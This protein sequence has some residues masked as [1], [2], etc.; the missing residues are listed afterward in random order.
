MTR[1]R[2]L[3]AEDHETVRQALKLLIDGDRGM[4]VVGEARDGREAIARARGL[5][6]DVVVLDI[7]MPGMNGL[8]ATKA[9]HASTPAPAIVALTRYRD[10]AYV[11]ALLAAGAAGYVLKQ[12]PSAELLRAI[13][14]AAEGQTYLDAA[15][16]PS[17]S[18]PARDGR[19]AQ[20]PAI[21]DREGEV[22]RMT[23]LGHSNKEI[24]AALD[25]SV[26]TVEVHKA[27][28]MRKLGLR[29][30]IDVVRFAILQGW[31]QEP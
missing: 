29:G 26:K 22:L 20:R 8:E 21:T 23:A 10:E 6:P 16:A 2:V 4:T 25:L 17:A 28:A 7:S 3:L 14:A 1:I 24:A 12:S 5:A 31:L 11:R 18:A 9:L 30:R 13:R 27:N 15:I 19:A